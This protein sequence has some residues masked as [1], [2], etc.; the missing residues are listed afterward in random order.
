MTA[1]TAFHTNV[2][3]RG[4]YFEDSLLTFNLTA[5]MDS[6]DVGKAVSLSTA[7]ANTVKLAGDG[8]HIVG[9][10]QSVE[11]RTV[12]GTLVGA[13]ELRFANTLPIKTG[14]TVAVGDTVVGAGVGEVK[15]LAAA[16]SA[17]KVYIPFV[18][19]EVDLLAG[20]SFEI[21]SPVAGF[22]SRIRTVVQAAVTTGD[23]ITVEVNTVAVTGLSVAIADAAAA[24]V[25]ATD[26]PT[27]ANSATTVVA[28]G[29]RI[30]I[31]PG[32]LFATAGRVSGI[33]EIDLASTPNHFRNIVVEIDGT[34]AIVV[35]V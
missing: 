15:A 27:T 16:S 20:T 13:V 31:I 35:K 1:G 10:L 11:D 12:E 8:D 29:D 25:R 28:A 14:E 17:G 21:V 9:R 33:L 32:S 30:E 34:D 19:D 3:L 4:F 2:S 5:G 26:T 7:A 24:G 23:T 6:D 18:F 22:I